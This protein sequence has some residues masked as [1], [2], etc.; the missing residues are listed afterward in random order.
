M[1]TNHPIVFYDGVCGLCDKSIQFLIARDKK[2][3]LRYAALQ[4]DFAIRLLGETAN[5]DSFIFYKNQHAY[6]HSTGAL[7]AIIEIGGFWKLAYVFF[8][9][10]AF[11]R[12]AIYNWVA[13]NRYNLFG[14]FDQCKTPSAHQRNLFIDQ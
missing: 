9:V 1:S 11:L 12:N 13:K 10:P 6:T 7:M 2:Q 14:K 5:M 4:S 3:K 8:I